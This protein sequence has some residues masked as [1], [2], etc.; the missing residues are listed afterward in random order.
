MSRDPYDLFHAELATQEGMPEPADRQAIPASHL[1][2][3]ASGGAPQAG[4][5]PGLHRADRRRDDRARDSLTVPR[6][7]LRPISR[8]SPG[9]GEA[10][11]SPSGS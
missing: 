11:G 5:L 3:A 9:N 10:C 2:D 7:D 1:G 4:A 6:S 8:H